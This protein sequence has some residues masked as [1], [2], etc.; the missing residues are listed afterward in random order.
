M[1]VAV[2]IPTEQVPRHALFPSINAHPL[3]W[4]PPLSYFYKIFRS[5]PSSAVEPQLSLRTTLINHNQSLWNLS[6]I[7]FSFPSGRYPKF[8]FL[9]EI[10]S[11][12]DKLNHPL[13]M[14]SAREKFG[15]N[16][17]ALLT[18]YLKEQLRKI[19]F[20]YFQFGIYSSLS[21]LVG[22]VKSKNLPCI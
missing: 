17:P 3:L 6:A 14:M 5:S 21:L 18:V 9:L 4:G 10:E 8:D 1:L 22:L 19:T 2:S 16:P 13:K 11:R 12:C 20:S 7:F 15:C